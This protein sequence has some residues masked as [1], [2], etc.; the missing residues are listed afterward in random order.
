G[1]DGRRRITTLL[2]TLGPVQIFMDLGMGYGVGQLFSD[3]SI[4]TPITSLATLNVPPPPGMVN[5]LPNNRVLDNNAFGLPAR[6]GGVD[7]F[8]AD[9]AWRAP[10]GFT[11]DTITSQS[12]ATE[13]NNNPPIAPFHFTLQPFNP[14][15]VRA[16]Q[17]DDRLVW[18]STTLGLLSGVHGELPTH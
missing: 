9:S 4:G 1:G 8:G 12:I 17:D 14:F 7:S 6:S 13:P 18:N 2:Y 10:A 3:E 5:P 11:A 16:L 15:L